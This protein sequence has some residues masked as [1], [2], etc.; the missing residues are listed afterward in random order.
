M[1]A[2]CDV[3]ITRFSS[4]VYIGLALGKQVYSDFDVGELK[5][6]LPVQNN[7]ASASNIAQAG[8]K[9]L[10]NSSDSKIFVLNNQPIPKYNFIQRY[11]AKR[12]LARIKH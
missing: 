7:A 6:L 4:V 1:I 11:K 9:L 3:L 5:K 2:N 8:R 12:K 10:S